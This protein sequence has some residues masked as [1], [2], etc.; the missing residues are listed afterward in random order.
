MMDR[1]AGVRLMDVGE[2]SDLTSLSIGTIYQLHSQG[3]L[4]GLVVKVG[5]LLRFDRQKVEEAIRSG[6]VAPPNAGRQNG[7]QR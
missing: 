7:G 4:E 5:R 3:R 6:V 2:L 1:A